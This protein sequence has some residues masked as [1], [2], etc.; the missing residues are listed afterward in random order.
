MARSFPTDKIVRVCKYGFHEVCA[1]REGREMVSYARSPFS[2]IWVQL[3]LT[4]VVMCRCSHHLLGF[5]W[6]NQSVGNEQSLS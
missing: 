1:Q 5:G 2:S 6:V 3:L 4:V